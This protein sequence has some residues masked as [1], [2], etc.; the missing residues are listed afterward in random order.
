MTAL[1]LLVR[2][3]MWPDYGVQR[4]CTDGVDVWEREVFKVVVSRL[5]AP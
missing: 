1:L 2:L 4:V 3:R 5:I